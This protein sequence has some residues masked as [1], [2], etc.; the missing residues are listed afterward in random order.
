MRQMTATEA[1]AVLRKRVTLRR[2]AVNAATRAKADAR[3]RRILELVEQ[4]LTHEDIAAEMG[5]KVMS[6]R[7]AIRKARMRLA[8]SD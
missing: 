7:G 5:I 6:V 8:S 4:G 1:R 3:A 2:L